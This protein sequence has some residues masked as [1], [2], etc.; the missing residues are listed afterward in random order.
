MAVLGKDSAM[1]LQGARVM[2][3][4]DD[5]L[6]AQ[7]LSV[8]FADRGAEVVGPVVSAKGA[9]RLLDQQR[10]DAAILDAKVHDGAITPVAERLIER[11]IPFIFHTGLGLP[12]DL[13]QRHPKLKV[14]MKPSNPARVVD[15]LA[16]T[17]GR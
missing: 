14:L 17:M 5:L 12:P 16:K 10:I 3:V 11:G 8:H 9:L 7:S 6:I 4:E 13:K 1:T 2:I 15:E